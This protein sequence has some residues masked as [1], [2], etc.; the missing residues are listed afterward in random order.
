MINLTARAFD[1]DMKEIHTPKKFQAIAAKYGRMNTKLITKWFPD[2]AFVKLY[3]GAQEVFYVDLREIAYTKEYREISDEQMVIPK[4]IYH[5][6]M[7]K[8]KKLEG[9]ANENKI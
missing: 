5:K 2:T 9:G 8:L 3:M 1:V 6:N 7:D 4:Y